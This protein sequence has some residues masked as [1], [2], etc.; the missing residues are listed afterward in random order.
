[1]NGTVLS[2]R[3]PEPGYYEVKH[4]FQ[5]FDFKFSDDGRNV[6]VKNL[7][8]F[9][10]GDGYRLVSEGFSADLTM[11]PRGEQTFDLPPCL[12]RDGEE[13]IGRGVAIMLKQD[14][15][16]LKQGHIVADAEFLNSRLLSDRELLSVKGDVKDASDDKSLVFSAA[17]V[18]VRFCRETGALISYVKDGNEYLLAPMTVDAFRAPSSNEVGLGDQGLRI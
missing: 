1:M 18:T 7:N 15:G 17:N 5:P 4:V 2:D 16:I 10:S 14:E 11:P 6:T 9:R 3:T 12:G 13:K 8:H